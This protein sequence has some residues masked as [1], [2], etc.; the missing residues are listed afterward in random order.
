MVVSRIGHHCLDAVTEL[1]LAL[2]IDCRQQLH[3]LCFFASLQIAHVRCLLLRDEM[4]NMFLA[5]V[6]Q[7]HIQLLGLKA[8]LAGDKSLVDEIVIDKQSTVV[9]QQGG[10]DFFLVGCNILQPVEFVAADGEH[11]ACLVVLL[12]R[13]FDIACAIQNLQGGVY[14]DGEVAESMTKLIDVELEGGVIARAYAYLIEEGKMFVDLSDIVFLREGI[15]DALVEF[16][17]VGIVVEQHGIGFL[18]I[19]PCTASLLEIGFEGVGTV[20]MEHHPYIGLVDA[21]SEGIGS[22][23]HAY[24]VFLPVALTLILD[25]GIEACVVEGGADACFAKQ[26]RN[27]LGATATAG[28]D[29]GA[30][31]H[32]LKDMDEF[33]PLIRGASYDI[34]KILALER[35][36]EDVEAGWTGWTRWAGN[37]R[38]SGIQGIA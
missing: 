23:H 18:S 32:A 22:D 11:Q 26:F 1:F 27:F 24:L 36:L 31:F 21:H 35:H 4:Q 34:G 20:D 38:M 19:A 2:L 5:Q 37:L 28:I 8:A 7:D 14:L 16:A 6:F 17:V 9:S 3:I 12:F 25:A 30:A 29:N 15:A 13:I 10:D 33:L